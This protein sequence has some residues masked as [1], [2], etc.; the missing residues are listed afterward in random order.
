MSQLPHV[1]LAFIKPHPWAHLSVQF[2]LTLV[3]MSMSTSFNYVLYLLLNRDYA[4]LVMEGPT[5]D[6]LWAREELQ[7]DRLKLHK[8]CC[9]CNKCHGSRVLNRSTI[10]V[11]LRKYRHDTFFTQSILISS[12]ILIT[13]SI[14]P[15][16][17]NILW[18]TWKSEVDVFVII[19]VVG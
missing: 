16:F 1:L 6:A 12:P 19:Y 10:R 3:Y 18:I 11:H 7:A 15:T 14:H 5:K 4:D 17:C 13:C 8:Y 2:P 9:P